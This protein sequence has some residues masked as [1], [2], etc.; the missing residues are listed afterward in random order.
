MKSEEIARLANVSRS[1]VSRVINNYS[2]VPEETRKK[3][4]A[5]ID[6]YGYQPNNSARVL[7][8][9]SNNIIGLFIADINETYSD[10]TYIGANSPY[11][12]ELLSEII[13]SCKKR[14]Y[15][16]LVN[17]ITKEAECE[18]METYFKSR[19]I[20]GGIFVGFPYRMKELI[21]LSEKPYNIVFVDELLETDK[22]GKYS[23]LVNCDNVRCGYEATKYLL[24]LGHQDIAFIEGDGRLSSI[25]RK[26]GYE[27][28]FTEN[29]LHI[30]EELMI[31]GAYREDI[32]YKNTLELLKSYKPS[33][34]F[35]SNDIM[36]LGAIRAIEEV[37]L[38]VGRDISVVGVD[39]L[40]L[41]KWKDKLTTMTFSIEEIA[42]KSVDLLFN[43]EKSG[44]AKCAPMLTKKS[45]C[46]AYKPK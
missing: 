35:A 22:E 20:Y 26:E 15:L 32:A 43:K 5:V 33:A 46:K 44:H 18:M 28:A 24:E 40:K 29:G 34:I 25:Q 4:Q 23:K 45:S 39:N 6:K 27:Q 7:A 12:I 11:N 3:V 31:Y 14:N 37:G 19:M 16:V 10:E 8:G 38:S 9:K 30:K 1:T 36:A 13:K 21:A 17:T 41:T 2:N 42:K